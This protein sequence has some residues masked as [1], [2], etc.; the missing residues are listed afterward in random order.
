VASLS[1]LMMGELHIQGSFL[2]PVLQPYHVSFE[3]TSKHEEIS[4]AAIK[5]KIAA[6]SGSKS[7]VL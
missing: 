4:E 3:G 2:P 6:A 5:N 1:R 7:F